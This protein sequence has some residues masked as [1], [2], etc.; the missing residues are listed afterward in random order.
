M[1]SAVVNTVVYGKPPTKLKAMCL[2]I[3]VGGVAFASLKKSADGAYALKFDQT[4]LFFGMLANGFAAFK[5]SENKKLMEDKDLK[6]NSVQR[7]ISAWFTP[8]VGA[9]YNLCS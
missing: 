7:K 9:L 2:P 6:V 5:G 1:V 8:Y 4:A 3:I